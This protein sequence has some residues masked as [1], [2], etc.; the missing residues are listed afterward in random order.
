MRFCLHTGAAV[1]VCLAFGWASARAESTYTSRRTVTAAAKAV[2]VERVDPRSGQYVR[3]I[4]VAPKVVASREI[5]PQVAGEE[6][7]KSTAAFVPAADSR[8]KG[9]VEE[10][11][12]KYDVNPALIDSV[13]QVESN[14]NAGAVSPKGAQGLMQ[15]MP[16]TARR[17]GVRN[18]F[19]PRE[20]IHGGVKYLKFLQETFKD[21]RLAIAAYN[22]GE[23]AVAKYKNVPPYPET[24]SYV[25]A[26]GK[27]YG[28]AKRA[29][30]AKS[31]TAVA[32]QVKPEKPE[33]PKYAPVRQYLDSEGRIHLTTQ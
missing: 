4:V 7:E 1:T 27:R 29:A 22:A 15:L 9:I 16:D 8:V 24:M 2:P 14:Y 5:K 20:N 21:D 3:T 10:A 11:A 30:E 25:A 33:E 12:L 31:K 28:K 23:G 32:A 19:D 17:F 6:M 13:I 26:V 18:T